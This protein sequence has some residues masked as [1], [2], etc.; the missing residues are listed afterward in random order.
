MALRAHG[1]AGGSEVACFYGHYNPTRTLSLAEILCVWFAAT[2]C[3][4]AAKCKELHGGSNPFLTGF[5][6]LGTIPPLIQAD[7]QLLR[8]RPLTGISLRGISA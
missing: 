6:T 3:A 8:G 2:Q 5:V 1:W 7:L 4:S